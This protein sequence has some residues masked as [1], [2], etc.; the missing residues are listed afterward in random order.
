MSTEDARSSVVLFICSV[1][2][3]MEH[4]FLTFK[5]IFDKN[6]HK[7]LFPGMTGLANEPGQQVSHHTNNSAQ[8]TLMVNNILL[9][10]SVHRIFYTLVEHNLDSLFNTV[11]ATLV[12]CSASF[13]LC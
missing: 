5:K 7:A 9:F 3:V 11:E 8:N 10:K 6:P 13:Q 1:L 2:V 12:F 4:T